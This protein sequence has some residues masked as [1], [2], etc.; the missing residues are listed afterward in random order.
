MRDQ[1]RSVRQGAVVLGEGREPKAMGIHEAA[2]E[3]LC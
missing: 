2:F 3:I 1:N